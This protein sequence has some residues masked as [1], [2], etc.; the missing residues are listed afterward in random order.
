MN[1][2]A[3]STKLMQA[4][5]AL[6]VVGGAVFWVVAEA[7][8]APN[9]KDLKVEAGDLRSYAAEAMKLVEQAEAGH[10]TTVFYQQEAAMLRQKLVAMTERLGSARPQP[11]TEDKFGRAKALAETAAREVGGLPSS[12][13]NVAAMEGAKAKLAEIYGQADA[14]EKSLEP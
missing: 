4:V 9:A 10:L 12:L 2:T 1:Q 8:R 5:I 3:Q 14:L 13:S 11:G 7:S 6:L